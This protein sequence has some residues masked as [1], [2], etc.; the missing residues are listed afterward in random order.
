M[1]GLK[2]IPFGEDGGGV[3]RHVE[4]LSLRLVKLGHEV[5]AYV[6]PKFTADG[7][8]EY[9]G[10]KLISIFSIPT[11]NLDTI[12]YTF[13]ATL[14]VIFQPVDI[15]HFH[16]VG[17]ST[18]AWIVR[19]FKPKAKVIVTFHSI[20]RFH[21]KWGWFARLYL[22]WG[23][24]TACHFAHH[25]I[26][27]SRAIQQYCLHKFN[28][29]TEYIPN[30]ISLRK[31]NL[32]RDNKI[33]KLGVQ[34]DG[35]LLTVAR[36]V[37]HK[38]IHYLIVAY[39]KMEQK[40]GIDPQNWPGGVIRKLVIVGAPSY[41][42]DYLNYL[43]KIAG[44]DKNIIF[45][46]FQTGETLAQL[47]ANAYLY[48]H[49]SESEG[50]SITILEALSYGKCVLSSNIPENLEVLDHGGYSFESKNVNDL[51]EKLV[52]LFDFEEDVR[53]RGTHGFKFVKEHFDWDNIAKEL[54]VVYKI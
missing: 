36:L 35:Y 1:I 41:T 18:L 31:F 39:K 48:V 37:K 46:G 8:T 27:V 33:K 45:A 54:E 32:N 44:D 43:K 25:T 20:D 5:I 47:F 24:W 28:K 21:K 14:N 38:G 51:Y 7:V 26:A 50:L 9:K 22:A 16:G 4:E 6:R 19:I 53:R 23:E 17:P 52:Y 30:G 10:V 15:V 49:P 13:L 40:F 34:K 29:K 42:H 11:K 3:E 2:G 12:T